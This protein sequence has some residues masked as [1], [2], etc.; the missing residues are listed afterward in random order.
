M[1]VV[2][3]LQQ[4]ARELILTRTPAAQE[5]SFTRGRIHPKTI[6]MSAW[7]KPSRYPPSCL[8][9]PQSHAKRRR[10]LNRFAML[11]IHIRQRS[12]KIC[13]I[14]IHVNGLGRPEHT[15]DG[16]DSALNCYMR[17]IPSTNLCMQFCLATHAVGIRRVR[18][19]ATAKEQRP[20]LIY[21]K[22]APFIDLP[23]LP[24]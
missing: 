5:W 18:L 10:L 4:S 8:R 2:A 20:L 19:S 21:V 3:I 6:P 11:L 23:T 1:S 22:S 7:S 15:V 13:V 17:G 16:H 9:S 24:P 12:D 14:S